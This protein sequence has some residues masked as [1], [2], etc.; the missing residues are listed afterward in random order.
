MRSYILRANGA[1]E[2]MWIAS[3]PRRPIAPPQWFYVAHYRSLT[4]RG[5]SA[6]GHAPASEG[7]W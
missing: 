1:V 4:P 5:G 7:R 6:G 2:A 3:L